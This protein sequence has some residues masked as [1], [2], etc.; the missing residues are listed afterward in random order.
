VKSYSTVSLSMIEK[1]NRDLNDS[2]N[3]ISAL[4][5]TED[6]VRY[7][8]ETQGRMLGDSICSAIRKYF[9]LIGHNAGNHS[10]H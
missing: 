8:R 10:Y 2:M 6:M 5:E 1:K 4:E 7:V 9:V 3:A